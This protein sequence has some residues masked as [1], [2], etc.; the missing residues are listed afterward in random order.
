M[1]STEQ[2]SCISGNNSK[3]SSDKQEDITICSVKGYRGHESDIPMAVFEGLLGRLVVYA[4]LPY[5]TGK[6][7]IQNK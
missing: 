1:L 7:Y 6:K 5:Q 3:C 2:H 4:A